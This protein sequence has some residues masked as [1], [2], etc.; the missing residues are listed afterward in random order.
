[1]QNSDHV[2]NYTDH[3]G[4]SLS[5]RVTRHSD[6]H[7]QVIGVGSQGP[8]HIIYTSNPDTNHNAQKYAEPNYAE[9]PHQPP[10]YQFA[11]LTAMQESYSTG[12]QDLNH[13]NPNASK[14]AFQNGRFQGTYNTVSNNQLHINDI[15]ERRDMIDLSR[16]S[17]TSKDALCDNSIEDNQRNTYCCGGPIALQAVVFFLLTVVYLAIGG[18]AGF[19]I[20]RHCKLFIIF[21]KC[22]VG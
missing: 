5:T 21:S 8:P 20:G 4:R 22:G 18:T 17:Q 15:R 3:Q 14:Y 7:L 11:T 16:T 19:F 9:I 12:I 10:E 6:S 2:Q 1:M 13:G